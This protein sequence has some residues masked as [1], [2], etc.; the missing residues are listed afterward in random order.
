MTTG[1]DQ[2]FSILVLIVLTAG[3]LISTLL[4]G[5]LLGPKRY[6]PVK[7]DSFECGTVSTGSVGGRYGVRFYLLAMTFIVFDVEI[8]FLYAWAVNLK[9]MGAAGFFAVLP[10]LL[11]LALG[12]VYEW[13]RGVLDNV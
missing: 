3:F 6:S 12:L 2:Y 9:E 7:D 13:R 11:L 5:T 8:V 10:F 4:I 1:L